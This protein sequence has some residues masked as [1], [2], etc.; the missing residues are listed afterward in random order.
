LSILQQAGLKNDVMIITKFYL[1]EEDVIKLETFSQSFNVLLLLTFNNTLKQVEPM[2]EG[3]YFKKKKWKSLDYLEK[4][5]KKLKYAHYYRPIVSGWNDQKWQIEESLKFGDRTGVSIIGGLKNIEGLN[6]YVKAR[7]LPP[8]P[9]SSSKE[10]QEQS[11]LFPSELVNKILEIH[12]ALNLT[13]TIVKDQSCGLTVLL[14][15]TKLTPNVEALKMKDL[16]YEQQEPGC[17]GRC[18]SS[19]LAICTAPPPPSKEEVQSALE[20]LGMRDVEFDITPKAVIL[21]SMEHE[22]PLDVSSAFLKTLSARFKYAFICQQ[23]EGGVV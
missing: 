10:G 11:K 8:L 23:T 4:H 21:H 2:G 1:T 22:K 15:K 6:E 7:G 13:S 16:L 12:Q 5:G 20:Q 9:V 3:K 14:S 19:Q 18:S 17:M